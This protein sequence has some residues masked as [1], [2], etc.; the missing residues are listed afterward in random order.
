MPEKNIFGGVKI[1]LG[2]SKLLLDEV[3]VANWTDKL[4]EKCKVS[5]SFNTKEVKSGDTLNEAGTLTITVTNEQ[6]HST[7]AE[8]S[9]TCD[10]IYGLES[11]KTLSLRINE[12]VN[13]LSGITLAEGVELVKTEIEMDGKRTTITDPSHFTPTNPGTCILIFTIKDKKGGATAFKVEGLTIKAM[14][15]K[16]MSVTHIK[17]V[18]I[19]PIIGQVTA[20]DVKCYD[21]IEHLRIAEATRIREM[22]WKYGAGNHSAGEYQQLMLRLN[23]GMMG[24]NGP[25]GIVRG[26][27]QRETIQR[28]S[29]ND[30]R[31]MVCPLHLSDLSGSISSLR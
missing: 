16:A 14:E 2:D 7:K 21:H 27:P 18:E 24:E 22:M 30:R 5:L 25:T 12:E 1:E 10:A 26:R 3:E 11:L 23:T 9:L 28:P 19:L 17:P 15:Y 4:T 31:S 20:G 29:W 6:E 13:L 8:I